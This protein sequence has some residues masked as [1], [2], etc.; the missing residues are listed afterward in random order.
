MMEQRELIEKRD[1]TFLLVL[2]ACRFDYFE[3]VSPL[4]LKG[5]LNKV[6]SSADC[7][8][9]V[10][11]SEW[12]RSTFKG[13]YKDIIYISTTPH[14]NSIT[15]VN[16]FKAS[17]HFYKI[18]DVWLKGWD[19]DKGTVLPDVVSEYIFDAV[20]RYPDKRVIA[21]YMQPH[22]PYLSI[23]NP[24]LPKQKNPK[25]HDNFKRNLRNFIGSRVRR[26]L[27]GKRT[28]K[29]LRV[30]GL[31]PMTPM[32]EVL[33]RDGHDALCKAYE[34]NVEEV[35]GS[36]KRLNSNMGTGVKNRGKTVITA[37]HG[38]YLGENGFY[39]HSF[40]PYHDVLNSVPWF[41]VE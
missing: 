13:T 14:I 25:A 29:L 30:L 7:K 40:L 22:F 28:R 35:L 2:D 8:R 19:D 6:V 12:A 37:D 5:D 34:K 33:R 16:G 38:E 1:W 41:I 24:S 3:K 10:A 21:H 17:D 20:E 31:P 27:G 23:K 4:Y 39:G 36:I 11:T 15:D 18:E 32:H 26:T 9:G